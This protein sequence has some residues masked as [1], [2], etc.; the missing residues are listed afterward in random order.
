MLEL[1]K[2][3]VL[4]VCTSTVNE[5]VLKFTESKDVK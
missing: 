1:L 3:L 4:N 2:H 5:M